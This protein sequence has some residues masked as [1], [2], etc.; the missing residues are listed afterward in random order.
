MEVQWLLWEHGQKLVLQAQALEV[1]LLQSR[2]QVSQLAPLV[3]FDQVK[4]P[5]VEKLLKAHHQKVDKDPV[6][7]IGP[8]VLSVQVILLSVKL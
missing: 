1:F 3:S 2:Q 7:L 6:I 4:G 8:T 5:E